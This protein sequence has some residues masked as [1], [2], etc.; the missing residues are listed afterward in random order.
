V[1]VT[2]SSFP[3]LDGAKDKLSVSLLKAGLDLEVPPEEAQ[4][5]VSKLMAPKAASSGVSDSRAELRDQ[6]AGRDISDVIVLICGHTERDKRCGIMGPLLRDEF[7]EKLPLAGLEVMEGSHNQDRST[8]A[9]EVTQTTC[10]IGLISHIGGHALAGNVIIYVPKTP[11]FAS[12]PL[13]GTGIWY[14]R[15]EPRHVEGI[16]KETIKGGHIIKDLLRGAV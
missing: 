4:T 16:I 3:T 2:N 10:R 6:F 1:L 13:A 15:V 8:G 11:K 7:K 12:H 5:L 9:T 14:G